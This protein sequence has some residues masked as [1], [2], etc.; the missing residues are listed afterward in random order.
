MRKQLFSTKA[1]RFRGVSPESLLL[2]V[3]LS[4]F[5]SL[6]AQFGCALSH[7][8][9]C[10]RTIF[11]HQHFHSEK[12]SFFFSSFFLIS[13]CS[14]FRIKT[15]IKLRPFCYSQERLVKILALTK[16]FNLSSQL[17]E[18][19]LNW[20]YLQTKIHVREQRKPSIEWTESRKMF[21]ISRREEFSSNF[22]SFLFSRLGRCH[23]F[24]NGKRNT[25]F[26]ICVPKRT[27]FQEHYQKRGESSCF[28]HKTTFQWATL[29]KGIELNE[30]RK[31]IRSLAK[32]FI[33]T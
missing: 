14:G 4:L 17:T 24:D 18:L 28:I 31:A 11:T 25:E 23:C 12:F 2:V 1:S 10:L 9:L 32:A 8:T 13:L 29:W 26:P 33:S 16:P 30:S 20:E 6:K 15:W 7:T 27:F 5:I 19:S 3:E 21:P 22:L